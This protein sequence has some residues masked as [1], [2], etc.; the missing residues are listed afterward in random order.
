ML[1]GEVSG[2]GRGRSGD[3]DGDRRRGSGSFEGN[4]GHSIVTNGDFVLLSTVR[5]GDAA[6]SKLLWDF[7]LH[8]GLTFFV[9][10]CYC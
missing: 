3:G 8:W 1:F 9:S 4:V 10:S 5:G 7:L 2:V 6:F